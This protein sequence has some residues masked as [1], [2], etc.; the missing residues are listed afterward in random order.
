MN[1]M[2]INSLLFPRESCNAENGRAFIHTR[3][4]QGFAGARRKGAN[5]IFIENES[6]YGDDEE[7]SPVVI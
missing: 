6:G 3:K 2:A 1:Q 7:G 5:V 4:G